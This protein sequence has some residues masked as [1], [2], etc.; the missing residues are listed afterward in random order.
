[1][2]TVS[3]RNKSKTAVKLNEPELQ[4]SQL[5]AAGECGRKMVKGKVCLKEKW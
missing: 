5:H 3:Q 2:K 1:M 4:S